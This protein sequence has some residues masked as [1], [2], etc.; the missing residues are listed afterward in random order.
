MPV[1]RRL[2]IRMNL[3]TKRESSLL[4]S[5]LILM[6]RCC[7]SAVANRFC[8]RTFL[9]LRTMRLARAFV[10]RFRRTAPVLHRMWRRSLKRWVWAMWASAWMVAKR[11][12]TSSV[13][14]RVHTSSRCAVSAI[15]WRRGRR[16][17]CAS[18]LRVTTCRT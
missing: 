18:R 5:W 9:N 4:T 13:V 3:R 6:C 17:A 10:R 12:T 16:W 11:L 15:V 1:P 7:C 14:N 2:S 8:V